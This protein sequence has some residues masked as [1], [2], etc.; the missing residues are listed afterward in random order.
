MS[1]Y[2]LKFL[3]RLRRWLRLFLITFCFSALPGK[4]KEN[5]PKPNYRQHGNGM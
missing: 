1:I 4:V 3:K 5:R 2:R